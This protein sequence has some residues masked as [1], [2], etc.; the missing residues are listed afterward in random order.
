MKRKNI[1][2]LGFSLAL[3]AVGCTEQNFTNDEVGQQKKVVLK[4]E[5]IG[6]H[7][8]T[9]AK[10]PYD[11]FASAR[12]L[13]L[14]LQFQSD[15]NN[16]NG[17]KSYMRGTEVAI[18]SVTDAKADLGRV[19]FYDTNLSLNNKISC[20]SCHHQSKAFADGL[21]FSEGFEGKMT[22]RNSM[23]LGN[24][25]MMPGGHFW[26]TRADC[27]KNL[28][29]E[30]VK[31][32]I[33]MGMENLT[34]LTKKLAVIDYYPALF[35]KA[36]GTPGITEERIAEGF[37]G[38]LR[39]F[40]TMDS[41]YDEGMRTQFANYTAEEKQGR[42]IFQDWNG[43]NCASCHGGDNFDDHYQ[44]GGGNIGL[45][46]VPVDQGI[47]NGKFKIP[48]LRNV[49]LTAPY[50]HDGRFKT[51]EEVVE[52]YN[53][54]VKMNKHLHWALQDGN[55]PKKLNLSDSDKKALVAFLKTLTDKSFTT[56]PKYSDPF[57]R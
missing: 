36:Y 47:E 1:F 25:A 40:V 11:N 19:L 2:L 52:H 12:F 48:S 57:Q 14:D 22:T 54:G 6:K 23:G 34:L 50:M 17:T 13:E 38:F 28:A 27:I 43:A 51:L 33:E 4:T 20:G 3:L 46:A 55:G 45:D 37:N 30:P 8:Y 15:K 16:F 35:E 49:E 18:K 24:L 5:E 31:N 10:L 42:K 44:W 29:L 32:H 26:D 41:K 53:S 7:K 56:N 21:K 39:S 9:T